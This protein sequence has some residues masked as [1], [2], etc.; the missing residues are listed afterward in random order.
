MITTVRCEDVRTLLARYSGHDALVIVSSV[1]LSVGGDD[2]M[3]GRYDGVTDEHVILF[4]NCKVWTINS[5]KAK[6]AVSGT[7]PLADP[8]YL[9]ETS[10]SLVVTWQYIGSKVTVVIYK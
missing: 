7:L 3:L 6:A 10:N 8:V 5:K 9:G 2:V 1:H 4:R